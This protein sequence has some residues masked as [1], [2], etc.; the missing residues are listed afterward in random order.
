MESCPRIYK[1]RRPSQSPLYALLESL[2]ERVK[3]VWEERFEKRYGFWKGLWD[4]AVARYLD[5]GIIERGFAR[6]VCGKCA[7]E[8]LVALNCWS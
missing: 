8:F 7:E 4:S 2:Y 3:L 5:C 6:V 1:P